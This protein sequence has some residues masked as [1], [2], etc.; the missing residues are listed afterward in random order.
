[1]RDRRREALNP[2]P[3]A[4]RRERAD[5]I[6]VERH[7]GERRAV[8]GVETQMLRR[9]A[10]RTSPSMIAIERMACALGSIASQAP[11]RSMRRRGPS[12]IATVRSGVALAPGGGAG[13]TS[14]IETPASH[15]L[16]DRGRQRQAGR[17]RAGD[18][19][20]ED[21]G[22]LGHTARLLPAHCRTDEA[23]GQ[24]GTWP[25]ETGLSAPPNPSPF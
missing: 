24:G 16:L 23:K 1:M 20:V 25:R 7:M 10:S 2:E 11:M 6:V 15:R 14:A 19:D 21:G 8:L 5:D 9:T 4:E 18:D 22:R 3:I 13:S 12:A 17:A